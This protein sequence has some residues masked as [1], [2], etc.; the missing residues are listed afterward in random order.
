MGI[1]NT[2][3]IFL[4]LSAGQT[5]SPAIILKRTN[6]LA[7]VSNFFIFASTFTDQLTNVIHTYK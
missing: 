5:G 7:K 4:H 1:C 3:D 2:F 6:R